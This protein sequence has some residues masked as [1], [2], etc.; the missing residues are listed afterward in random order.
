MTEQ[1]TQKDAYRLLHH[2]A[3]ALQR[4]EDQGIRIDLDYCNNEIERITNKIKEIEKDFYS[5]KFY[6]HWKKSLGDKKP[7]ITSNDQLGKFLYKT[8]KLT[9]PKTTAS[10]K[11]STDE[12]SLQNLKIPALDKL[13]RMRRLRKIRDTYLKGFMKE[14]VNGFIHPNFHLHLARTYRSSS[15]NP[16][17]QNI[18]KR[19]KEAMQI[20]RKALYPR[21]GHQ[22]LE[23][24]FGALEVRIAACYHQDPTMLKYIRNPESDMHGDMAQQIFMLN[25]LDKSKPGHKTLRAGAKNGFVFPQFYGD[26]YGNNAVSLACN[27]GELPTGTW[28]EGQGIEI[29]EGTRLADHLR[30]KGVKT[31][32]QFTEHLKN[33]E[34]DFW[35]RRFPV[36]QK[37]K[38]D[39]YQD[40]LDTGYIDMLT[41]FRCY[42]PMGKNDCINYPVQGSAFHCLLWILIELE[43]RLRQGKWNSRIIGQIHDAIVFDVDPG[44]LEAL[45]PLVRQVLCEELPKTW[46][47]INVPLDVEMDL[48]PVNASWA[49]IQSYQ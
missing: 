29:E 17:F 20:C 31:L 30:K 35:T 36:Y 15:S 33:I 37:W 14:E 12:K 41:G 1:P 46:K 4:A 9:P 24:D 25:K 16:N 42:G 3:L 48:A 40:Y 45:V 28:K 32:G 19:D 18:P 13:L 23:V 2:G 26:Y 10:G 8:K 7:N 21:K 5:T 47:W 39:W 22:L 27:W 44:E 38:E 6:K 43:Q 34:Q 49:D 11:G